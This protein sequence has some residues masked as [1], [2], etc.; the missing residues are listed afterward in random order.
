MCFL[1]GAVR[2]HGPP[3]GRHFLGVSTSVRVVAAAINSSEGATQQL[4]ELANSRR[5]ADQTHKTTR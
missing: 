5:E 1:T 2:T 4:G 3:E